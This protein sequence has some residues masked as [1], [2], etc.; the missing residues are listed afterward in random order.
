[1]DSFTMRVNVTDTTCSGDIQLSFDV[2]TTC[3]KFSAQPVASVSGT[4]YT[5]FPAA[6]LNPSANYR[7]RYLNSITDL[8][9]NPM[10][11]TITIRFTTAA[12]AVVAPFAVTSTTP[13]NGASAV[14]ISPIIYVDFT[15]SRPM[16]P[17][18]LELNS[19][20]TACRGS[21]QLSASNFSTCVPLGVQYIGAYYE[22]VALIVMSPLA[23]ATTY[24][25]RVKNAL[26]DVYGNAITEFTQTTGFTTTATVTGGGAV[27]FLSPLDSSAVSNEI[28]M[29]FTVTFTRVMN[30][31][32]L[33]AITSGSACSGSFMV[34]GDNFATCLPMS[35]QPLA[36]AGNTRFTLYP[37]TP[38]AANTVYRT[39]IS[40]A[41]QDSGAAAVTL[42]TGTGVTTMP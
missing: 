1:M 34:S 24:K 21:I 22:N 10:V 27:S 36:S 2:F 38:L 15:A 30:P 17:T 7:V 35:A 13:T 19:V 9:G 31:A 32:T 25:L 3:V 5:I 39:R 37:Q 33:T 40:T 23:N 26:K 4:T 14:S 20:D 12:T 41:A 29:P 18:T 28:Y 8:A 11:S 6:P 42:Y 16:D